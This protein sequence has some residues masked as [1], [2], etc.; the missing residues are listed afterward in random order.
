[1]KC[2]HVVRVVWLAA[3]ACVSG[4]TAQ[5]VTPVETATAAAQQGMAVA[6]VVASTSSVVEPAVPVGPVIG[7]PDQA[8]VVNVS[9]RARV[10][11]D[12]PLI[13]GFVVS[14]NGSRTLLLRAVGP[15]LHFF[16]VTDALNALR[17]QLYDC[18]QHLIAENGGWADTQANLFAVTAAE[19]RT[20]AFPLMTN[21]A[22]DAATVVT[23][24]PGAYT[25]HVVASAGNSGV[26][27]AEIYDATDPG[28]SSR[29]A[30]ISTRSAV[31]QAG[32]LISGFI[33]SGTAPR[34]FLVRAIGPGLAPFRVSGWL[35]NPQFTIYDAGGRVVSAND[36]WSAGY[37]V[38]STLANGGAVNQISFVPVDISLA[39]VK[40]L[41][42]ASGEAGAFQ[43]QPGSADAALVVALAPGAYTVHVAAA[44]P[45]AGTALLEVYELP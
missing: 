8:R 29:L 14:G 41:S 39:V 27:L 34:R 43:L 7:T 22:N 35:G 32:D 28:N 26:A 38:V 10:A 24:P 18:D 13:V 30:N 31:S 4:L 9:T 12:A 3:L 37:D 33:V 21:A 6:T 16:G 1:M 40:Q 15:T 2:D 36:N 25:L 42:D 45:A 11:A 44:A 5:V 17:L 23:L 20:G 19:R